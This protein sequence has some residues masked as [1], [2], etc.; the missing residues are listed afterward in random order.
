LEKGIR[1]AEFRGRGTFSQ[2]LSH[3]LAGSRSN[4]AA[5]M[6]D[7]QAVI[8][9]IGNNLTKNISIYCKG[10]VSS[11]VGLWFNIYFPFLFNASVL[12]NG[13]FDLSD[14]TQMQ[15]LSDFF[16]EVSE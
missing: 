10:E 6:D 7:L 12:H 3:F 5:L 16:G 15:N 13:L 2:D 11:L 4:F 8:E 14:H 9:F 1:I